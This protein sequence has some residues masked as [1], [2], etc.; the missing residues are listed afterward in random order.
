M[1][2]EAT[3]DPMP[4]FVIKAKDALAPEAVAAYLALCRGYGLGDQAVEVEKALTEIEGW[5]AR[6]EDLLKLPDHKHI[7][8]GGPQINS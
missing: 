2:V 7:P 1:S 8:V 6:N 3:N 5:Q 4:V